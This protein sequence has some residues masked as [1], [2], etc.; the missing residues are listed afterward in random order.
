MKNTWTIKSLSCFFVLAACG[1]G[2]DP[3]GLD[4][5]AAPRFSALAPGAV[6]IDAAA[7]LDD[8]FAKVAE[9]VPGFAG[10]YLNPEGDLVIALADQSQ[11]NLAKVATDAARVALR[12][13]SEPVVVQAD[14]SFAYLSSI[15]RQVYDHIE[16]LGPLAIDIDE[17]RNRLVLDVETDRDRT[18]LEAALL[19]KDVPSTAIVVQAVG[20]RINSVDSLTGYDPTNPERGGLH[21]RALGVGC[22]L[23]FNAW[24]QGVKVFS[25]ASHC[26]TTFAGPDPT[27]QWGQPFRTSDH[28]GLEHSDPPWAWYP[29][30]PVWLVPRCRRSDVLLGRYDAGVNAVVGLIARTT[31]QEGSIYIDASQPSYEL[32]GWGHAFQ[33]MA[34][35]MTGRVSGRRSGTVTLTCRTVEDADE[36]GHYFTCQHQANY[37]QNIGDSGAPILYMWANG[38]VGLVGTHKGFYFGQSL[39]SP[40]SGINEDFGYQ[41]DIKYD[42]PAPS[43]DPPTW[44]NIDPVPYQVKPNDFCTWFGSAGGGDPPY[45][46]KW[47]KGPTLVQIDVGTSTELMMD[48]GTADFILKLVAL[49]GGGSVQTTLSVDVTS[50]AD[51]CFA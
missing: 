21:I 42:P 28:I 32:V 39:F 51:P 24:Y 40:M 38:D 50:S 1:D 23:G 30:C 11:A 12:L 22:T 29:E 9:R 10:V 16:E 31:P 18:R 45:T 5:N 43:V 26:S 27:E 13:E 2:P 36:D 46:F 35:W 41:L 4:F 47:Y 3:G 20:G 49:N 25:T 8:W 48:V 37:L 44:V 19:A 7:N 14:F 34:V 17:Q 15:R 33:N 6:S